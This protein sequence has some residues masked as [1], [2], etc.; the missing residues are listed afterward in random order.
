MK[1]GRREECVC[2]REGEGHSKKEYEI[3]RNSLLNTKRVVE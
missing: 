3:S 2:E 1:K